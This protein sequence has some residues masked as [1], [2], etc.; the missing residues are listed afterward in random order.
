MAQASLE[1]SE[2]VIWTGSAGLAQALS[3]HRGFT[4]A[5]QGATERPRLTGS[6]LFVVGS[7]AEAS[8]AAAVVLAADTA[9]CRLTV[10]PDI[11][12]GGPH[13]PGWAPSQRAILAALDDGRDLLVEI[14]S[15]SDPDLSQGGALAR[16][17]AQLLQPAAPRI[18]ALFITGGETALALLDALGITGIRLIE[19]VEPGVP[20]GETRG[21]LAIP[22]VTKAGAFG[23]ERTLRRC[24][25]H[26]RRL[27][28][29]ETRS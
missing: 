27:R 16:R 20:L 10:T 13:S 1:L 28:R 8:R 23:D 7:V 18:G 24:L 17:L 25:H 21:A 26:F 29:T 4:G 6:I 22:I 3:R 12:R 9:V 14:A 5:A 2:H 19:E 11:L 15:G